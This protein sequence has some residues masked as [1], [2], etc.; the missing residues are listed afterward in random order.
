MGKRRN[1]SMTPMVGG[2]NKIKSVSSY[3]KEKG[4]KGF[5]DQIS[6]TIAL[7]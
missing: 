4:K 1:R 6:V 5:G 2:A 7:A 3:N